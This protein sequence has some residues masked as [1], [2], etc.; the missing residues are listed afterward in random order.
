MTT[1]EV[2]LQFL[3]ELQELSREH[4]SAMVGFRKRQEAI[5]RDARHSIE[6]LEVE[7]MRQRVQRKV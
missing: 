1:A 6:M 4:E 7:A 2:F 5:L 3:T